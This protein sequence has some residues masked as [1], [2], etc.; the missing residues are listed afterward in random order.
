MSRAQL[1][2]EPCI[3]FR[4]AEQFLGSVDH[5]LSGEAVPF[6]GPEPRHQE[7]SSASQTGEDFPGSAGFRDVL[8]P[9]EGLYLPQP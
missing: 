6:L 7:S 9:Q 4:I 2:E 1:T 5:V 3:L 8:V